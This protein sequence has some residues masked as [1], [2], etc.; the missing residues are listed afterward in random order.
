MER[1]MA[2]FVSHYLFGEQALAAFPPVVQL[3]AA[4]RAAVFNWGLQGPDPLFFHKL[5]FGSPLH[6]Y[7]NLMHSERTDEL[8]FAFAR[9]V[10]RMTGASREIAESYFYG[11]LCHYALDNALH[12]YVYCRQQECLEAA[13]RQSTSAVH[14]QIESDIDYALYD[15]EYHAP[16]TEF[17]PDAYYKLTDEE[18]AV[19]A[20]LLHYLLKVVYGVSV[21]T[22]ALRS[23]FGEMLAVQNFLYAGSRTFYHSLRQVERLIRRGAVLT[24]HIKAEPP[25]WNCLNLDHAPWRNLWQPEIERTESVPELIE[26]ARD[27]AVALAGQYA[28]EFD[29]GWLLLHHFDTPFDHGSPKAIHD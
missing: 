19:L 26:Q 6:K 7:G 27:K 3:A 20:V 23:S 12:P 10:N 2:D 8:F 9:A 4:R 13:P 1:F 28:A 22:A 15:A 5:A 25:R 11:F 29:A 16:V 24:S 14:C 21:D 18:T 17:D